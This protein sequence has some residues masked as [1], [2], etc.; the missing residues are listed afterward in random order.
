MKFLRRN[1]FTLTQF[2]DGGAGGG[3]GGGGGDGGGNGGGGGLPGVVDMR[4][5]LA[6][7]G[8]FKPDWHKA[9]GVS[10][11]IAKKFTRPEALARSYETLEKQIGAK[12]VIIPGPNATADEKNAYYKALG[13]PDKPEEY[14]FTK[15]ATIKVG[16]K[17]M[18]VPDVAW[19]AKRAQSWQAKLHE[20]GV[21]KDTAN[22]I[23]SAALEESVTG[24]SSIQES[25]AQILAT[26]KAALQKEWG[27]DYDKN[28]GAAMR[29]A[30][31][32]GGAELRNHP[33]LGN[34]PIF[35]KAMAKAGAAIAERPGVGTRQQAGNDSMSAAEAN[36]AARKLT[37]EIADRTKADRTW[38]TSPEATQMKAEKSRLFQLANPER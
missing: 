10:E 7:D 19:D 36:V 15:P 9:V 23:M 29:A 28:M 1:L 5:H 26:S 18:P 3:N 30:E 24:L 21:P 35:I 31:T 6:D 37:K 4:Q 32:F 34:D 14:G 13:R 8:T 33:G 17:D 22:R 11:A 25:Q 16:D 12:G 20:M 2:F 38:A 27:A